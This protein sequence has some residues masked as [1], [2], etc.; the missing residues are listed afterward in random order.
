MEIPI[1]EVV[2]TWQFWLSAVACYIVCEVVKRIPVV[3]ARPWI[4]NIANVVIGILMIGLLMG[5]SGENVI[6]GILASGMA[7]I[8]YQ[9]FKNFINTVVDGPRPDEKSGG[10]D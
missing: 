10:T 4:V 9:L 1:P 2:M 3:A 8:A 7:D 5:W 6:Y